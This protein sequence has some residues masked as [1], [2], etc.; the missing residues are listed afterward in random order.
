MDLDAV[1]RNAMLTP[2]VALVAMASALGPRMPDLSST[3]AGCESRQ[4]Q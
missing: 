1:K 3:M 4:P 2:L